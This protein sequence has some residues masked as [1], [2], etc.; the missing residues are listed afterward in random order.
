LFHNVGEVRLHQ[1]GRIGTE[2]YGDVRLFTLGENN[3]RLVY[4][5][6]PTVMN[7]AASIEAVDF[8]KNI[9]GLSQIDVV[10]CCSYTSDMNMYV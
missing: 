3:I 8:I 10:I 9:Q 7:D 2:E 5:Y 6:L 1:A 4:V